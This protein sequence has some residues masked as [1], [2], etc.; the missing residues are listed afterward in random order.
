M[1][2]LSPTVHSEEAYYHKK[3]RHESLANKREAKPS[4]D[5]PKI[6]CARNKAKAM[7]ARDASSGVLVSL[8]EGL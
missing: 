6:V 2:L 8:S 1:L 7:I 4:K 3:C 5:F